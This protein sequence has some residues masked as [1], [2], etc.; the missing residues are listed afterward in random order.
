MSEKLIAIHYSGDEIAPNISNS[1]RMIICTKLLMFW[2][3]DMGK[4]LSICCTRRVAITGFLTLTLQGCSKRASPTVQAEGGDGD[5]ADSS[6][7]PSEW[8]E[9]IT[10]RAMIEGETEAWFLTRALEE[11]GKDVAYAL[12]LFGE[13]GGMEVVDAIDYGGP[14][15]GSFLSV[16]T[17]GAI[18]SFSDEQLVSGLIDFQVQGEG[19]QGYYPDCRLCLSIETDQTGNNTVSESIWFETYDGS[20][21]GDFEIVGSGYEV[22]TVYGNYYAGFR[23]QDGRYLVRRFSS[24]EEASETAFELDT[25]TH[26]DEVISYD[27]TPDLPQ[28]QV[29]ASDLGIESELSTVD[30]IVEYY[31]NASPED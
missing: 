11:P 17:F 5:G 4:G 27:G 15:G 21:V 9:P 16:G 18:D 14:R 29:S 2:R 22:F 3:C 6:S 26:G 31:Q 19:T 10:P 12:Y 13:S 25:P 30:S 23:C 1:I 24:Y 28:E 8:Q 7:S 20:V